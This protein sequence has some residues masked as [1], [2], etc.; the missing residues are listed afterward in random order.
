MPK[1]MTLSR[2]PGLLPENWD[3]NSVGVYSAKTV[4]F[5]QAYVNLSV[6][7]IFSIWEAPS[8]D[9]LVE[10]MEEWGMPFEEM[11]DVQFSQS[12]SEMQDRLKQLGRI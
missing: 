3:D 5:V 1:F 4:R 6:G 7:F 10:Q 9:A 8:K 2:A 12:A 11:H